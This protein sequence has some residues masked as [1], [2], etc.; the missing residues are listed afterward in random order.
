MGSASY[1][2]GEQGPELF[3]PNTNGS[4]T[5]N[6]DLVLSRYQSIGDPKVTEGAAAGGSNNGSF[7]GSSLVD[8]RYDVERINQIDYVTAS[9]FEAGVQQAAV[10]GA[11]RGEASTLRTLRLSQ[12]ARKRVVSRFRSL[13]YI[14]R[15][16]R[17]AAS[18]S[19]FF[20]CKR[21]FL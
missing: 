4:I 10:E 1:L 16:R 18:L 12:T 15:Q 5:S 3:T 19:E 13:T 11:R 6:H 21:P 2:V 14:A 9:Q 7:V 17:C 20:H 8:V